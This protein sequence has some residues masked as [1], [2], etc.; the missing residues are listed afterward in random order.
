MIDGYD[1]K[2]L[3]SFEYKT[4]A[5]SN[6]KIIGTCELGKATIQLL[7]D[8]N[9]FSELKGTWIKTKFG[10]FYIEDVEPVQE[11]INIKLSCYDIKY[12]LD[13][14]Y[15]TSL[16]TFP[17]TL[18]EWRNAIFT[19][20]DVEYDDSDFPNSDLLLETEPYIGDAKTNRQVLCIIAQAGIS[21][22]ETDENDKFYF[23]W[24]TSNEFIVKDW[25]SLT[26]EK[27]PTD[28][29]NLVVLGRGDVEDIVYYPKTKPDNPV[30]FKIDNNYI[31][32]PQ[33]T[34][35]DEDLRETTIIPIYD[36]VNGL[37]YI[38]YDLTATQ[39]DNKLSIKLGDKITYIDIWN[40]E[41]T[42]YIMTRKINFIGGDVEDDDNYQIT[43]S[44]EEIEETNTDLSIGVDVVSKISE[45]SIKVD[46]EAEKIVLLNKDIKENKENIASLTIENNAIKSSVYTKEQMNELLIDSEKGL[47]NIFKQ[48]GG[49]NLLKNSALYF[50]TGD[51]FDYWAGD[52]EKIIYSESQ[53]NTAIKLKNNSFKQ[54]VS[55]ANSDYNLSFKYERL[56]ELGTA[57]VKIN[58]EEIALD[59]KG[60]FTK[61]LTVETNQIELEFNTS[62]D[63]SYIIYELMLNTGTEASP[64]SQYQNEVHT[65]TVNI[66]KG[67]EVEAT[68]NDT[69]ATMN[70]NGFNVINKNTQAN[71]LKATDTGIE[72]TDIKADKGTIGGV[73]MKK[74]QNQSWITGV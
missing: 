17:M 6:K 53:S 5:I 68:E 44:A 8:S 9:T 7:N 23:K 20:C 15:D 41:L 64:W 37:N 26:T 65:D 52:A 55:L 21:W 27:K 32:D 33:D 71:V 40:N 35:S 36:R 38:V 4:T 28:S 72:T 60:T 29:V 49:N 61:Q 57:S 51:T 31:L 46:K 1:N 74:V 11:K 18:K 24:F 34:T 14:E 66:S 3:Q 42:S 39:I 69:K 22:I 59:E 54:S 63:D 12:K 30:E 43:L 10:S 67:I 73:L 25:S 70:A 45:V 47:T 2:L 48:T 62:L 50:K 19:S 56:N 58:N 13:T 16:Y